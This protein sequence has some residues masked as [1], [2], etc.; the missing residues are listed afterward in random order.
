V[1][2][3]KCRNARPESVKIYSYIGRR[4]PTGIKKI[5]FQRDW[6][7]RTQEYELANS[8]IMVPERDVRALTGF[9]GLPTEIIRRV[10]ECRVKNDRTES[11]DQKEYVDYGYDVGSPVEP[12]IGKSDWIGIALLAL[13]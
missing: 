8:P 2:G 7:I 11:Q 9:K 13:A 6:N 12:Q 1:L 3:P 4:L 5:H 10:R